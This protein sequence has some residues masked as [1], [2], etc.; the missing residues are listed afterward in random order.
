M[1]STKHTVIGLG[2]FAVITLLSVAAIAVL[3]TRDESQAEALPP[4]RVLL[5]GDSIMNQSGRKL[6]AALEARPGVGDVEVRNE[7]ANGT[8]L[9]TPQVLDWQEAVGPMVDE[10]DPDIVV[11]LFVGNYSSDDLWVN[12]GG[13]PVEPYTDLFFDEWEIQARQLHRT[14]AESGADVYWVNPP[15][16]IEEEG[17]RRVSYFRQINRRIAEDWTGVV[18][19]DGTEILSNDDGEYA[20]EL[21]GDDG[22]VE[23]VRSLDSVHLTEVGAQLLA[24]EIARQTAP[25]V[26]IAQREHQSTD[27]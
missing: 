26:L 11:V 16:M 19:I 4:V 2:A 25:S 18:L 8:G 3:L 22:V 13:T 1:T 15:P 7:G 21:E 9:L 10:F 17:A 14:I 12:E 20:F 27:G 6:E 23:Q 5:I 24:D